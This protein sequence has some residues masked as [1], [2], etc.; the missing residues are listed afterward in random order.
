[1]RAR[2]SYVLSPERHRSGKLRNVAHSLLLLGAMLGIL[3][4]CAATVWGWTGALTAL[5]GGAL[6]LALAP[7][8]SP[9][10]LLSLYKAREV[11]AHELPDLVR[12][13][14]ALARRA[15]LPRPRLFYVPSL[16]LNAF[17]VG[18]PDASSVAVT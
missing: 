3:C 8:I 10:W 7:S 17:A 6:G 12:L 13:L 9:E 4:L 5:L 18:R 16:A 1:M 14:D 15:G 2:A 11:R